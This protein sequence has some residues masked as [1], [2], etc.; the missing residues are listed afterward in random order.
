MAPRFV[1]D[2]TGSLLGFDGVS[3]VDTELPGSARATGFVLLFGRRTI[4]VQ[5]HLGRHAA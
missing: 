4:T 3:D 5:A 2:T 1:G